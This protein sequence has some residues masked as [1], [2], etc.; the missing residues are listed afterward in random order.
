MNRFILTVLVF[1]V[2][3]LTGCAQSK[4]KDYVVKIK[5]NY[6][7]MIAIL[8][9]ETPKHKENFIKLAKEKY[10]DSTL[11]HRVIPNFM[12]QGGDPNSKKAAPGQP[13]GNGGPSYTIP[14]EFVPAYFHEKGSLSAARMGDNVNPEKASSGSQ[15]YIVQGQVWKE[16]DLKIDQT[17]IGVGLQQMLSKPENKPL[18]DSIV[19]IYQSGDMKAY[20]S[21]IM[22]LAPRIE[23]ETGLKVTKDVAAA[24]LSAY[25]TVGGAPHLDDQYTVFGK[26]IKGL[27]VVDK[28]AAVQRNPADRPNEDIRMFISVEELPKKKVTQLYGYIYPEQP[29]KK[30]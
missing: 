21:K 4:N 16:S 2:A 24:R 7:E 15:F 1:S 18:Y 26:V 22:S 5:T 30:K 19:Q 20:E 23:K 8:Y 11:F 27:E 28:I 9:D 3:F 12:I 25:T 14:A 6:G 29:K 10:F 17:K 13:L